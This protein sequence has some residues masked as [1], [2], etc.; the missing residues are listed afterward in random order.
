M[1]YIRNSKSLNVDAPESITP[2]KST[3]RSPSRSLR[4]SR[5]PLALKYEQQWQ[6]TF[7]KISDDPVR[8]VI[9]A[10]GHGRPIP[11]QGCHRTT[12]KNADLR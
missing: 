2:L 12:Q 6:Y 10:S 11:P 8:W 9:S 5:I 4:Q 3:L 7:Q 1:E